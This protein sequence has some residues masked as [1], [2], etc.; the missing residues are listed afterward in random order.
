MT[1][2]EGNTFN[3]LQLNSRAQVVV[4]DSNTVASCFPIKRKWWAR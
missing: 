3:E 4:L 2:S 1:F